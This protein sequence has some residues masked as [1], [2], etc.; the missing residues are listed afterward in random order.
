MRLSLLL[1]PRETGV[2][3]IS[4]TGFPSRLLLQNY[5]NGQ[6]ERTE[7]ETGHGIFRTTT[8]TGMHKGRTTA[9][10]EWRVRC[11]GEEMLHATV[12]ASWRARARLTR[13]EEF[14][15]DLFDAD[16]EDAGYRV[17]S[18]QCLRGQTAS[19]AG[20]CRRRTVSRPCCSEQ[21]MRRTVPMLVPQDLS[22]RQR[23]QMT[24]PGHCVLSAQLPGSLA[25]LDRMQQSNSETLSVR[26]ILDG[27]TSAAVTLHRRRA[28][29]HHR[30]R[31]GLALRVG[32]RP[33]R[34]VCE[35]GLYSTLGGAHACTAA[36]GKGKDDVSV[37]RNVRASLFAIPPGSVSCERARG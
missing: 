35:Q 24:K 31:I 13:R 26:T 17:P 16:L 1:N 14:S 9:T 18:V 3:R 33:A 32:M 30:S 36:E 11:G 6:H 15:C 10:V 27:R 22:Q 2:D 4:E 19:R 29:H 28:Q 25:R 7:G 21:Q 12:G 34:C 37:R 8:V 5:A 23:Q 20:Q